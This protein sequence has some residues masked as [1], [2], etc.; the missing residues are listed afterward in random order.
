MT[1]DNR[2]YVLPDN[3]NPPDVV[4][5]RVYVP[6]DPLYL[7][8]FWGAYS[9][10]TQW[11]AWKRDPFKRGKVAA[12]AWLKAYAKAREDYISLGA[13]NMAITNIRQNPLNP[14]KLEFSEDGTTWTEFADMKDC[15]GGCGGGGNVY[16]YDGQS[17]QIYDDCLEDW[18]TQ[19]EPT[20]ANIAPV[21][22]PYPTA[23]ATGACDA[24]ASLA[25]YL[26][27]TVNQIC[28]IFSGT[29]SAGIAASGLVGAFATYFG[30]T[31]PIDPILTLII[32]TY[33]SVVDDAESAKLVDI[34]EDAKCLAL[35]YFENNGT[36]N[37]A[38]RAALAELLFAKRDSYASDTPERAK[39]SFAAWVVHFLTGSAMAHAVQAGNVAGADCSDCGWFRDFR[40]D[41]SASGWVASSFIE[42]SGQRS[43]WSSGSGW[44]SVPLS[45][46]AA[47][48]FNEIQLFRPSMTITKIQVEIDITDVTL[49]FPLTLRKDNLAEGSDFYTVAKV[50]GF[51]LYIW[52]GTISTDL[53]T[54]D[55]A[56]DTGESSVISRVKLWGTGTN[57]F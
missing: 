53:L 34:T 47:D 54:I 3:Y 16:R 15:G 22:P 7:R 11:S 39:W 49:T 46:G 4:C 5:V 31:M 13:C 57:P 26:E 29:A 52:E 14:C 45:G 37:G 25:M 43:I 8:E 51:N 6:N 21:V 41:E 50:E 24:A 12:L 30:M 2:G 55:L 44:E 42:P 20:T 32:L 28:D 1:T 9:Y 18:V 56:G 33:D 35:P 38:N 40:F 17:I 23:P 27:Y 48:I 36:M 10:F 19:G